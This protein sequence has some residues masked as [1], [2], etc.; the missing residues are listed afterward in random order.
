ML[1]G[2]R[3]RRR[4]WAPPDSLLERVPMNASAYPHTSESVPAE[5]SA[6]QSDATLTRDEMAVYDALV[7]LDNATCLDNLAALVSPR[8]KLQ[9]AVASL[10]ADGLCWREGNIVGLTDP[11]EGP[12]PP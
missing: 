9:Q 10:V 11:S 5:H 8:V 6:S 12:E 7:S 1:G 4:D 3:T 2:Q